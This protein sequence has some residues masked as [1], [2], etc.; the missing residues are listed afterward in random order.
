MAS[1]MEVD[2]TGGGGGG[3]G[4]GSGGG[5]G[6][7]ASGQPWVPTV[8]RQHLELSAGVVPR[9]GAF[10][11]GHTAI[12]CM[13]PSPGGGAFTSLLLHAHELLIRRVTVDGKPARVVRRGKVPIHPDGDDDD[14]NADA[15]NGHEHADENGDAGRQHLALPAGNGNGCAI[16]LGGGGGGGEAADPAAA[17]DG[18]RRDG[19]V[20][21]QGEVGH[22]THRSPR[23]RMPFHQRNRGLQCG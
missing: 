13:P 12:T 8:R 16:V 7:V 19:Q 4:G 17:A 22:D 14:D 23:H 15:E 2:D 5:R 10:V 18:A 21:A 6:G 20:V 11:D 9:A 1:A 3:G